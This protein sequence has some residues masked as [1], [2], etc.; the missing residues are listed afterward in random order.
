MLIAL[1]LALSVNGTQLDLDQ[2]KKLGTETADWSVHGQAHKVTGVP[3]E[4]VLQKAGFEAGRMGKDVPP[5]EKRAGLKKIVIATASD[6]FEAI[7]SAGELLSEVGNT[8]VL[9]VW[10]I[11]GKPLSE[12]EAPLR[13]V[14]LT[15]KDPSRSLYKLQSLEIADPHR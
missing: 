8:R 1:L 12:R 5:K 6:G 15:D 4:K 9:V 3:L 11:D 7:F 10:E 2:L 13:I 14:V